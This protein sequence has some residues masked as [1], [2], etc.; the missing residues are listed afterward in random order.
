MVALEQTKERKLVF[1]FA[2]I[3]E[4]DISLAIL[5]GVK[6]LNTNNAEIL[7]IIFMK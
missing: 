1:G 6:I 7:R 3:I 2:R 5:I 4:I